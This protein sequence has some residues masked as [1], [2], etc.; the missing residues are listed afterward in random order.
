MS[1]TTTFPTSQEPPTT[2]VTGHDDEH[3]Y[4]INPGFGHHPSGH[5]HSLEAGGEF[6]KALS[7]LHHFH[8]IHD[9]EHF[10]HHGEDH[11]EADTNDSMSRFHQWM[12]WWHQ[13]TKRRSRDALL[14][15]ISSF[16]VFTGRLLLDREPTAYVIHSVSTLGSSYCIRHSC[17]C[18]C[19]LTHAGQIVVLID[20][21]LIHLMT[22]S[23]WLSISGEIVTIIFVI[24]FHFTGETVWELM[25]TTLL[26]ALCSFHLIGSR[27]KHLDMEEE[28]ADALEEE[29]AA[30]Q[31]DLYNFRH[32]SVSEYLQLREEEGGKEDGAADKEED[33]HS[34]DESRDS[35]TGS[36]KKPLKHHFI[37]CG[38]HF[39]E[40]FLDGSAGVM[41]TSFLGLIIDELIN[42]GD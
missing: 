2:V 26:A 33:T 34:K 36:S 35:D 29:L 1:V 9:Q 28:L 15:C 22:N 18:P 5:L 14:G 10:Q 7:A 41:Y 32:L 17:I 16:I 6:S 40:H 13:W 39:F 11:D 38:E 12:S 31:Q 3:L 37:W 27:N 8:E 19:N 20:M 30:H 21:L 23:R 42:Y 4:V 25:E 24:A